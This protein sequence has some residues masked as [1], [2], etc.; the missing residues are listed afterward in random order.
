MRHNACAVMLVSCL[1]P[2][3]ASAAPGPCAL[4]DKEMLEALA[5]GDAVMKVE[6]KT[7]PATARAPAQRIDMCTFTPRVG[8]AASLGVMVTPLPG[9]TPSSR[10]VCNE[11]AVNGV[12]M[13]SCFGVAGD[14]MVSVSLTSP[15]ATFPELNAALRARIGR[16]VD[17][18]R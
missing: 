3:A 18:A 15:K 5:L 4:V 7:V 9:R 13:A 8:A 16:L 6:H 10:P 12:G 11:S 14:N 1:V 2:V 17:A